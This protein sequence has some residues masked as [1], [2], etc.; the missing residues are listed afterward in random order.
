MSQMKLILHQFMCQDD[1]M[2]SLNKRPDIY[3]CLFVIVP[4]T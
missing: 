1:H 2:K 3:L 4:V